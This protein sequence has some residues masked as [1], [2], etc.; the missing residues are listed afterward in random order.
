[1]RPSRVAA[2]GVLAV[3]AALAAWAI[4]PHHEPTVT[5]TT[6]TLPTTPSSIE[7]PPAS[8][9]STPAS[10][11]GT[12]TTPIDDPE[13]VIQRALDGW[14]RFAVTGELKEVEPWFAARGPQ[15]ARFREEAQAIARDPPGE[16][17]Y[18]VT[19]EPIGTEANDRERRIRSEVVFVRTGE[20]SQR[21]EWVFVVRRIDDR[22]QVWTVENAPRT[23]RRRSMTKRRQRATM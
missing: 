10:R 4:R 15:M 9:V 8:P 12:T 7:T 6:A 1:M 14:G 21:F 2:A 20:P 17:A 19:F 5:G 3:L 13:G 23:G 16:P 11:A 18:R 22:W